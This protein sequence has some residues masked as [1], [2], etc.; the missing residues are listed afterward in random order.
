MT[1][2]TKRLNPDINLRTLRAE[3]EHRWILVVARAR[4]LRERQAVPGAVSAIWHTPRRTRAS[5][6]GRTGASQASNTGSIPVARLL[7]TTGVPQRLA[8]T[9]AR[10]RGATHE[11]Q[12]RVR[13]G[14]E[15]ACFERSQAS[16][17]GFSGEG[18]V[19]RN[20]LRGAGI[21]ALELKADGGSRT[22]VDGLGSQC[23]TN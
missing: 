12:V 15:S 19:R 17:G 8:G 10:D 7:P 13:R 22:R 16:S 20:P 11:G 4:R 2:R 14:Y 21:A 3:D 9:T 23:S 1:T 6:S 5:S 18:P